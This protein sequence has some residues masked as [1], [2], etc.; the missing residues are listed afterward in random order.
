MNLPESV[1]FGYLWKIGRAATTG[2]QLPDNLVIT[3][4]DSGHPQRAAAE[5]S[6]QLCELLA[7]KPPLAA[8]VLGRNRP[9]SFWVPLS[10]CYQCFGRAARLPTTLFPILQGAH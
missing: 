6:V 9:K 8:S 4:P 10:N 3:Q 5:C 1:C 2:T 7:E